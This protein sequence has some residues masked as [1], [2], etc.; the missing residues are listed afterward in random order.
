MVTEPLRSRLIA[1][2]AARWGIIPVLAARTLAFYEYAAER[3][4]R[5]RITSGF[6]SEEAEARIAQ[7]VAP[8]Q[9]AA[10]GRS[11]HPRGRAC[12]LTSTLDGLEW[13]AETRPWRRFHMRGIVHQGTALHLHLEV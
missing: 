5:F 6:R 8:G 12:D 10:P 13:A 1:R 4:F 9:A 11:L 7:T 2:V 3:G